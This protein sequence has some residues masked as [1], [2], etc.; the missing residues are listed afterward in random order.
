MNHL[1]LKTWSF[2]L[3]SGLD[4]IPHIVEGGDISGYIELD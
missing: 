3:S 2:F 1:N 4:V